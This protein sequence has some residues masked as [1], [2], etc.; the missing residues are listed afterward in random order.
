M[1]YT[2]AVTQI[3]GAFAHNKSIESVTVSA[4]I[5]GIFGSFAGCSN[6]KTVLLPETLTEINMGGDGGY[7][8][9]G[10]FSDCSSLRTISIPSTVTTIGRESFSGCTSLENIIL[11]PSVTWIGEAAFSHCTNL[12]SIILPGRLEHLGLFAFSNTALSSITIPE[13][14]NSIG[15]NAFSGNDNLQ[16]VIWLAR[17]CELNETPESGRLDSSND[18]CPFYACPNITSFIFGTNVFVLPR[19]LCYG[20]EQHYQF[21]SAEFSKL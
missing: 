1:T 15:A 10:A 12:R 16:E 9:Y 2:Y 11:S 19:L 21:G 4:N 18:N 3:N 17:D 13:N 14:L 7:G 20:F 8:F 5:R 6:L